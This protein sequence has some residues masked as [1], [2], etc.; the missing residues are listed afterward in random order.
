[1]Q[2]SFELS[3]ENQVCGDD[4]HSYLFPTGVFC[5]LINQLHHKCSNFNRKVSVD[6]DHR[7][8]NNLIILYHKN[9]KY[10]VLIDNYSCL[11]IYNY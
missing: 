11:Q 4:N 3:E 5:C 7:T 2:F 1:M 10:S 9:E 6:N 8:F